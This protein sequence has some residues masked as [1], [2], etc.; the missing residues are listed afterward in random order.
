MV[1]L[2]LNTSNVPY[3]QKDLIIKFLKIMPYILAVTQK[4]LD[5]RRLTKEW[6]TEKFNIVIFRQMR[7]HMVDN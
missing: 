1:G 2:F 4:S 7:S 3:F 6:R 5:S